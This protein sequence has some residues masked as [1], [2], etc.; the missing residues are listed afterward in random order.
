MTT[1]KTKATPQWV[2]EHIYKRHGY[3]FYKRIGAKGGKAP[4]G[5]FKEGEDLAKRAGRL[6]GLKSQRSFHFVYSFTQILPFDAKKVAK[7]KGYSLRNISLGFCAY[8]TTFSSARRDAEYQRAHHTLHSI[9]S[10]PID[11]A[12]PIYLA[13]G[14][15]GHVVVSDHG[16]IIDSE[17]KIKTLKQL[18][19]YD[20]Y[21]WGEF[22]DGHR[23]IKKERI[24]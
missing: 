9:K 14:S 18:E 21:G 11:V 13:I 5:G 3:D 19:H 8:K 2:I 15:Y 4:V 6:G 23:V 24:D 7:N 16:K 10:L 12:V 20:I 22:C 17:G 1:Q